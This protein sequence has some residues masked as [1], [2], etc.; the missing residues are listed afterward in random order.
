[1]AALQARACA[2]AGFSVM[3]IDLYGCGDSEG[4]FGDATWA[5]WVEDVVC[6]ASW[7]RSETGRAPALW[8]VRAGCLLASEAARRCDWLPDLLL[9][10]PSPSGQQVLQQMLR[11][12][13]VG[14]MLDGSATARPARG[15]LRE[16]LAGGE[17][18]EVAGYAIGPELARG[19]ESAKLEFGDGGRIAWLEVASD[20]EPTL[21]PAARM[22]LDALGPGSRVD[23]RVVHG[24]PF[25]QTQEITECPALIDATLNILESWSS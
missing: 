23:A 13:V 25:W 4:D 8:A 14:Q 18:V 22:R 21:S 1:M 7:L 24:I 2:D 17:S 16:R 20:P 12:Q 5:R 6:A 9:W 15:H 3:Q 11:L 10:Q 19:L